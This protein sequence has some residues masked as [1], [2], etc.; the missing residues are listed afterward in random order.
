[1]RRSTLFAVA[2][3]LLF[4]SAALFAQVTSS[5]IFGTVTDATGAVVPGVEIKVTQQETNFTRTAVADESGKYVFNALP[6]GTYRVEASAPGFKKFSQIG[7]VLEV[8]RNARVDP[9]IE[10]GGVTETVSITGD[11]PLVNTR[12]P[13][14]VTPSITRRSSRSRS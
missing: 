8:N 13:A 7:I 9:V 4:V 14:W 3:T 10:V 1:M 2:V 12:T 6:L 5:S 11:A